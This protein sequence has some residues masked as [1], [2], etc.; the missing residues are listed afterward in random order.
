MG[1]RAR[2]IGIRVALGA[3]ASRVRRMVV[4]QALRMGLLG[5]ALGLGASLAGG[6][7]L[8]AL[9]YEVEPDDP[10]TLASIA[11][12]AVLMSLAAAYGPARRATGVDPVRV[13]N[14]E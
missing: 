13:L 4:G 11:G 5:A 14:E 9:L 1:R 12:L 3:A 10:L 8:R 2:E 7:V 6:R